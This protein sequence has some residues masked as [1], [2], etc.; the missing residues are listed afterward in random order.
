MKKIP[1]VVC[2][3]LIALMLSSACTLGIKVG[4]PKTNEE[5]IEV[6]V[7]IEDTET[8]ETTEAET[9]EIESTESEETII[10]SVIAKGEFA[11]RVID[12]IPDYVLD[13]ETPRMLLVAC[14]QTKPFLLEVADSL[15]ETVSKGKTYRFVIEE[16]VLSGEALNLFQGNE[17]F[18]DNLSLNEQ[19]LLFDLSIASVEEIEEDG[20][21]VAENRITFE[22]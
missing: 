1:V 11:A 19:L 13:G 12:I 6:E 7:D 9:T 3:L 5:V 10:T 21:G 18:I 4:D 16:K 14:Y 2:L 20:M 15:L 8:V 17:K 22:R